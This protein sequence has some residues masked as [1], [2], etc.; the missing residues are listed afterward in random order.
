MGKGTAFK[1]GLTTHL[2]NLD[3][4]AHGRLVY[5]GWHLYLRAIHERRQIISHTIYHCFRTKPSGSGSSNFHQV[6]N[7]GGWTPPQGK[8]AECSVSRSEIHTTQLMKRKNL[9]TCCVQYKEQRLNYCETGSC[10]TLW[11]KLVFCVCAWGG[12]YVEWCPCRVSLGGQR[13]T[14]EVFFNTFPQYFSG[15]VSLWTWALLFQLADRLVSELQYP[16]ASSPCTAGVDDGAGWSKLHGAISP[17]A[18]LLII[19]ITGQKLISKT[20]SDEQSCNL[21]SSFPLLEY[22]LL[23]WVLGASKSR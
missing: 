16:P 11:G 21:S 19:F 3:F 13:P 8:V 18:H 12:V 20:L 1:L 6:R 23:T 15:R 5:A 10:G 9:Q 2:E 7:P 17:A 14:P 4:Q 22:S